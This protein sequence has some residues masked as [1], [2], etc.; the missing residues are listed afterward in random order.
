MEFHLAAV[1][2]LSSS[3]FIWVQL[4]INLI[5]YVTFVQP[6]FAVVYKDEDVKKIRMT[7]ETGVEKASRQLQEYT[8]CWDEW[9]QSV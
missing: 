8:K 4:T 5:E 2:P 7:I 1:M 6:I 3:S 9:V